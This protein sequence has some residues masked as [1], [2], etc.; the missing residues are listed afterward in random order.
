MRRDRG[1]EIGGSGCANRFVIEGLEVRRMLSA[2][3][4]VHHVLIIQGSRRNT[5]IK[6]TMDSAKDLRVAVNGVE[7]EFRVKL[8]DVIRIDCG[9][10]NDHVDARDGSP[11]DGSGLKIGRP[12]KIVLGAGDDWADTDFSNCTVFGGDGNDVI[13]SHNGND[14]LHGGAGDDFLDSRFGND[15]LWGDAG[16]DDEHAG[17]GDDYLSGGPGA[18]WLQDGWGK[19]TVWGNLGKDQYIWNDQTDNVWPDRQA[20]ENYFED[21]SNVGSVVTVTN[22]VADMNRQVIISNGPTNG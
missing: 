11:A 1:V 18:D 6:L 9:R 13:T 22:A 3:S 10:G 17:D 7:S 14:E 21:T 15:T 8:F 20:A 19:D 16:N 2:A 5:D 12:M 4:I